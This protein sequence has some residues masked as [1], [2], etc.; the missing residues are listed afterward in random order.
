M[1]GAG[2]AG[3][4]TWNSGGGTKGGGG[5]FRS[6][7]GGTTFSGGGGGLTFSSITLTSI[8]PVTFLTMSRAKPL[9]SA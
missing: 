6:G 5:A 2:G 3:A 9:A 4:V 7:G 1:A 8:G